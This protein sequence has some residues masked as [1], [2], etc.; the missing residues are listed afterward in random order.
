MM[1]MQNIVKFAATPSAIKINKEL[2]YLCRLNEYPMIKELN[3]MNFEEVI[4]RGLVLVDYWA[5]WCAPCLAQ[6]PILEKIAAEVKEMAIVGKVDIS[7]NRVIAEQQRVKN[8]PTL[9][10]YKE[11]VEIQRFAGVQSKEI[12]IK[13]IQKNY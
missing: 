2:N 1:T 8:I 13:S 11:G 7:D 6:N 3:F 12:I 5:E 9:V 10:L 4:S